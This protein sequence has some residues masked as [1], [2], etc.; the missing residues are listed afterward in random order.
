MSPRP[1]IA[2]D[3]ALPLLE[4]F[5]ALQGP[6]DAFDRDLTA[7]YHPGVP[8][9]IVTRYT[10]AVDDIGAAIVGHGWGW[11]VGTGPDGSLSAVVW[12]GPEGRQR[13]YRGRHARHA[14]MALVE[15]MLLM[16]VREQER[17][18]LREPPVVH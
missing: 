9:F 1:L 18:A 2:R 5:E 10:H 8:H 3:A 15:A 13:R 16:T 7:A 14:A 11:T 4:R 12:Q 17:E 6:S